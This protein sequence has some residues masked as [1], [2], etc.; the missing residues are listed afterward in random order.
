MATTD[1]PH[2]DSHDESHHGDDHGLAHV[3]SI[4]ML[5]GVFGALMVLTVLTV[6]TAKF[7]TTLGLGSR[8]SL[9]VA[10]VIATTKASLVCLYFMHLRYDKPLHAV[11]FLSSL[12]FF[13]LFVGFLLMDSG[14][15]QNEL[16]WDQN[17]LPSP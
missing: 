13:F 15:Y 10:L 11:A 6:V 17:H 3:A 8:L 16:L 9:V 14:Q 5:L 1:T 12:L 2:D 4:K 7:E